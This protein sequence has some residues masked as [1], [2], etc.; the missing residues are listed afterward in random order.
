MSVMFEESNNPEVEIKTL[1]FD[2]I[3]RVIHYM[4]D[5]M[6][7]GVTAKQARSRVKSPHWWDDQK[8][9]TG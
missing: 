2:E 9:I 7:D 3:D 5:G 8:L 6:P 1:A 4:K